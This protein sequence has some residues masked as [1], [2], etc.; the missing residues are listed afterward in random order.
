MAVPSHIYASSAS[1]RDRRRRRR[2]TGPWIP[3]SAVAGLA[4]SLVLAADL[5]RG[6]GL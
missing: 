3:L 4:V 6:L 1:R 2:R 5:L